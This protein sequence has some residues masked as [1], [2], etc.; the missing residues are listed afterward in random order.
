MLVGLVVSLPPALAA[1]VPARLGGT[2]GVWL[3]VSGAGNVGGLGLAYAALRIGQVAL[4]APLVS[5]EG[6]IAAAI[7]VIGGE[8]LAPGVGVTLA[9]IAGGVGLSAQPS[10]EAKAIAEDRRVHTRA[11]ALAA[12]AAC[13]F[14]LSLYATGRAGQSLPSAWVAVCPRLVGTLVLTLPLI[15]RRRLRSASGIAPLVI[16]AGLCEVIG[17]Y[18][19]TAGARHGIAV[20]AV[21]ASQFATLAALGGYLLFSERLS[22]VQAAGVLTVIAGVAV[23][24]V[25]RA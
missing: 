3:L 23:L 6:A 1:G 10:E 22:R 19:F 2:P 12:S 21:L 5:T 17:F 7:A 18:A 16:A 11:V 20:T 25:L 15:A 9:V 13:T 8:A 24:S 14:G 4:V